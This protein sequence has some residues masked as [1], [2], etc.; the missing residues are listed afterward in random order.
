MKLTIRLNVLVNALL[1]LLLPTVINAQE[2]S[3][4]KVFELARENYPYTRQKG[5]IQQTEDINLQN[6][7]RGY[8]PQLLLN[9]QATYQSDVTQVNIPFQGVSITPLSKDQYKATADVNQVLYDGGLINNQKAL[10]KLSTIVE[11]QKIEV[12]LHKIKERVQQIYLSVL[13]IDE[14]LKQNELVKLDLQNGYRKTEALV[15][16]GVTFQSNLST[17]EAELLKVEQREIELFSSRKGL[18][19]TLGL[20]ID[21][22]LPAQTKLLTPQKI[23]V[24]T[25]I[26]RPELQLYDQQTIANEH[27]K[28]LLISKNLPK[29]SIF[30]QGGYG[31]PGLNM[32]Q[33]QFD[34]F[35]IGGVRL[36]WNLSNL[37]TLKKEKQLVDVQFQSIEVQRETFLLN[38]NVQLRQQKAEIDKLEALISVDKKIIALREKVKTAA[39]AQL[40]NQVISASDI[41]REVNAEDMAK[42]TLI[43]HQLQL[44]QARLNY[45]TT[46]GY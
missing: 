25:D 7:S 30:G 20:F 17:I 12:E 2:Y 18:I 1:L 39:G 33:N 26:V 28:K 8:L 32:L 31:R 27:Q 29:A 37:Y 41:I 36:N 44:L 9:G 40:E 6:L 16:N 10:Q 43:L 38:T 3:L 5:L 22:D 21:R 34:W 23:N 4:E 42:Q 45:S 11:K 15:K 46:A 13:M 24:V 19:Q 35:Y 14:Q